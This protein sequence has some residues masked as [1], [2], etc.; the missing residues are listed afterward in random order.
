MRMGCG[1]AAPRILIGGRKSA[2]P[3]RENQAES[4]ENTAES[5]ENKMSRMKLVIVQTICSFG[6][7]TIA[8]ILPLIS[9]KFI[10][11]SG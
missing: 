1:V 5:E 11:A 9:L 7:Q 3:S 6:C 2:P 8:T 10:D 4:E